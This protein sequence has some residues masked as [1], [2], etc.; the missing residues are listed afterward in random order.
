MYLDSKYID[1]I[2]NGKIKLVKEKPFLI[3]QIVEDC[4]ALIITHIVFDNDP[5][6]GY[7]R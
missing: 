2:D 6:D 1:W 5:K 7:R 3:H 4:H